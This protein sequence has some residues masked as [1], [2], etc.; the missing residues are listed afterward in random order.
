MSMD[1][2]SDKMNVVRNCADRAVRTNEIV[3][4]SGG[5]K[6]HLDI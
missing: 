2:I 1:F 3:H 4:E 5:I 6:A